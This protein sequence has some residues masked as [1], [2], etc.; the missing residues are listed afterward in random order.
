M[1]N[2]ETNIYLN[3]NFYSLDCIVLCVVFSVRVLCLVFV[4]VFFCFFFII[5]AFLY[6]CSSSKYPAR[7][8]DALPG[9][10]SPYYYL[11]YLFSFSS[12][13]LSV[14]F[15]FTFVFIC[16][17]RVCVWWFPLDILIFWPVHC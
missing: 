1:N 13:I 7:F 4:F 5:Y 17:G 11:R 10:F 14:P 15:A 9:K 16:V 12:Y 8:Y 3:Y 6:E 2:N